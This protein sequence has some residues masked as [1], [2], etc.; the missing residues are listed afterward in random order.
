[1]AVSVFIR[2]VDGVSVE[3]SE[4]WEVN[5]DV[6]IE[7][8]TEGY[9]LGLSAVGSRTRHELEIIFKRVF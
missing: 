5:C 6:L 8:L 3:V 7:C 2:V 4:F 9:E 1:M